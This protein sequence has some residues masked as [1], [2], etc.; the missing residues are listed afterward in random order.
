MLMA[1]EDLVSRPPPAT[2][3]TD[4]LASKRCDSARP[5]AEINSYLLISTAV[6]LFAGC[7]CVRI[8]M[9]QSDFEMCYCY[10]A[11][12]GLK[13]LGARNGR[14]DEIHVVFA[15]SL[16]LSVCC[17]FFKLN[18]FRR[19]SKS[20]IANGHSLSPASSKG[21]ADLILNQFVLCRWNSASNR[22]R[23]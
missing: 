20:S 15:F 21:A 19:N 10:C 3:A 13:G 6:Q 14:R 11:L 2:H 16:L 1:L 5:M 12:T 17:L 7:V 9:N 23:S 4:G 18:E 22:R 8:E